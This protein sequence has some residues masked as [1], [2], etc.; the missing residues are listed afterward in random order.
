MEEVTQE[1]KAENENDPLYPYIKFKIS[2]KIDIKQEIDMNIVDYKLFK[3]EDCGNEKIYT[4]IFSEY[5]KNEI[6]VTEENIKKEKP[7]DTDEN[8]SFKAPN[9]NEYFNCAQSSQKTVVVHLTY[10]CK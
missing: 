2:R 9:Q 6:E 10:D 4:E 3:S 1:I 7:N 8:M 5:I